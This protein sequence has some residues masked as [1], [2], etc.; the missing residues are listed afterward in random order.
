MQTARATH[1]VLCCL[2]CL[3]GPLTWELSN[4]LGEGALGWVLVLGRR[5]CQVPLKLLLLLENAK[6][7]RTKQQDPH[8][9]KTI[10]SEQKKA[11]PYVCY[12]WMCSCGHNACGFIWRIFNKLCETEQWHR[13]KEQ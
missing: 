9:T 13:S 8:K 7:G 1:C 5:A 10:E 4:L 12:S 6:D 2:S 11:H 3:R